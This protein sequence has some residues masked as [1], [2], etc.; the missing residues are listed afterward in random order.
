METFVAF[1]TFLLPIT[2][3]FAG[4]ATAISWPNTAQSAVSISADDG[5]PTQLTQA[6]ILEQYSFRGTFYLTAGRIH[7]V[8]TNMV[9]WRNVFQRGHEVG[10]H[11]Y[12]HWSNPESLVWS[13]LASDVGSMEWW[14]LSNIYSLVPTD[15][16][17][18]YPE[19][20]YIIGPQTTFQQ[21][22]VGACEYAA[23]LSAVVTGARI[24]GESAND[25]ANIA[26]RRFY[27]NGSTI[28]GSNA[29]AIANAKSAIDNG[30]ANGTWTVLIFHSLGDPGDGY[31]ISQSAYTQ[32]IHY[33]N[34]KRTQLWV[35][36]VVTVKNYIIKNTPAS[37]WNCNLPE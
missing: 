36:P 10:N 34:T 5:W 2:F 33:L 22:Q 18:A 26:G 1:V 27:I 17:Y 7:S 25:P 9:S 24:V 3:S 12:S 21:Q 31:S 23:L 11:S 30:I 32:I 13:Q 8:V 35:A 14:L 16:T 15:H 19:G 4:P 28:Y 37:E 6:K 20:K 29:T